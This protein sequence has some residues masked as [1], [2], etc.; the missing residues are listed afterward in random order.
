MKSDAHP[1]IKIFENFRVVHCWGN[2]SVEMEVKLLVW[3][4]S[5]WV[6]NELNILGKGW[7]LGQL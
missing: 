7:Y 1:T 3:F 6:A 2:F 4:H 5:F